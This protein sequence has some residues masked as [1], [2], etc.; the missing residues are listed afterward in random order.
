MI[1]AIV[2]VLSDIE[3]CGDDV[4]HFLYTGIYG[5]K[6]NQ[7]SLSLCVGPFTIASGEMLAVM[8]ALTK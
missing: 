6:I 7:I 4:I 2:I 8:T 1:C 5:K 3:I